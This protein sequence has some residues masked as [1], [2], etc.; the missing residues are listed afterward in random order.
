M[1]AN[2]YRP[3]KFADVLGQPGTID[4]LKAH[5]R[6]GTA[7]D[8]SYIFSGAFGSGKTTMGRILARAALCLDLDKETCEPCNT[9]DNCLAI[10]NETSSAYEERDAASGGTI[11]IVRAMVDDI[12][13]SVINAPKRVWMWDE[14]HR[15]S[16]SSQDV[17]L[18]PLEE[19]KVVGI[20]CTT[21]VEKIRGAIRSRCE[22]YTIRKASVQELLQRMK[23]ILEKEGVVY[24]EEAVITVIHC[25]GGH[26]RDILGKLEMISCLGGVTAASVNDYLNLGAVSAYYEILLAVGNTGEMLTR[27]EE[28]C[29][30][31]APDEVAAGLAEAAMNSFRLAHKMFADFTYVNKGLASKVYEKYQDTTVRIAEYLLRTRFMSRTGLICDLL[32]LSNGVPTERKQEIIQAPVVIVPTI[33]VSEPVVTVPGRPTPVVPASTHIAPTPIVPRPKGTRPDGIGPLGSGDST[34]LTVE[35][36]RGVPQSMPRMKTDVEIRAINF[37]HGGGKDGN[38]ILSSDEWKREFERTYRG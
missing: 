10:L 12:P 35:D 1:W 26:I 21:E 6:K 29:E 3:L 7:L 9:C 4:V 14:C 13:F 32:A 38:Q 23:M 17:L 34:A 33:T 30:K 24:E 25:C 20:F 28:V 31:N 15:M 27:L 36:H 19:K 5:L 2:K 8:T 18:K 11:D 37:S 22:E 16:T